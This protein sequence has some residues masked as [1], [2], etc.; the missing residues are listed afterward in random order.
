MRLRCG[1]DTKPLPSTHPPALGPP[2]TRRRGLGRGIGLL[3]AHVGECDAA[4]TVLPAAG[5][6]RADH[7]TI[8]LARVIWLICGEGRAPAPQER[9]SHPGPRSFPLNPLLPEKPGPEGDAQRST[10]PSPTGHARASLLS[11]LGPHV[12]SPLLSNRYQPH[13][14]SPARLLRHWVHWCTGLR[15]KSSLLPVPCALSIRL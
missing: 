3:L 6:L 14:T 7:S 5:G 4:V 9:D 11:L 10:Q 8:L 13:S 2:L 1:C 12:L 15:L